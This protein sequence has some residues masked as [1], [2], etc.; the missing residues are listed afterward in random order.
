VTEAAW[1]IR[2]LDLSQ[3]EPEAKA[4]AGPVLMVFWWRSLPLGVQPFLPEELPLRRAQL[5]AIAARLAAAQ[6]AARSAELGGPPA[7]GPDGRPGWAAPLEAVTAAGGVIAQLERWAR[8]ADASAAALSVIVC[9]RDRPDSLA[10]CLES[11][12]RQTRGPGEIIVVD[13][14]AGRTAQAVCLAHPEV[15]YV[16]EPRP[17]LS[18]ARNTG[19][20]AS[21]G[22]LVAFTDDDVELHPHW[23][24]EIVAAFAASGAQAVTGVV[25]PASLATQAQSAFEFEMGGFTTDCTPLI[26]D[27]RFFEATR[28]RG[29]QVWRVGAGASMAFR[30]TV[31]DEVGLFDERLGAGASGCSED[32]ELWYRLLAAGGACLY[33]PR[34][35]VFH[36]HREDWEGLR[37]QVRAYMKGHVSALIVQADRFGHPGN[38]RRAFRQLPLYFGRVAFDSLKNGRRLRATLLADEVRGWFAGLQYAF[39]PKWRADRALPRPAPA[40]TE[41]PRA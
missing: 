34:A 35:V 4:S 41:A 18:V 32:S 13:N 20:R 38:R 16:H 10:R 6:L 40:T 28:A 17:G 36:H 25:F 30:R 23:A 9:T 21:R 15:T 2:H 27:R 33:E 31:F 14:S 39:R 8:P 24:S 5:T 26:F 7:A 1:T 12:A 37:R 3:G 29:A 19:V 22:E 11:L